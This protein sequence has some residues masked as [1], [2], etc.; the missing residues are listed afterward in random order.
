M[1]TVEYDHMISF[2]VNGKFELIY[3]LGHVKL[4]VLK[5]WE[6]Y[7]NYL[8]ENWEQNQQVNYLVKMF[9]EKNLTEKMLNDE[10]VVSEKFASDLKHQNLMT[11]SAWLNPMID[12]PCCVV[13]ND[14]FDL[15]LVHV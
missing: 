3:V 2:L 12:Q 13:K 5:S 4:M 14:N 1:E 7:L 8:L 9:Q 15:E 10:L 11:D 6:D